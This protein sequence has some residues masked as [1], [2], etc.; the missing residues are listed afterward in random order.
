MLITALFQQEPL[1]HPAPCP[2]FGTLLSI[3]TFSQ[4]R[5]GPC[6]HHH[7]PSE[8]SSHPHPLQQPEKGEEPQA[9]KKQWDDDS[10]CEIH[11]SSFLNSLPR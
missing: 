1:P 8:V 11:E 5:G 4:A 3:P 6:D 10:G 9:A 2:A 7:C